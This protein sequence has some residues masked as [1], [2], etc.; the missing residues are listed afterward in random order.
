MEGR[1]FKIRKKPQNWSQHDIMF[2]KANFNFT[3][4]E[5]S[6]GR[7]LLNGTLYHVIPLETYL[8]ILY[9][10]TRSNILKLTDNN[11]VM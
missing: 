9:H 10:S 3:E 8:F 1:P 4:R 11:K 7:A 5:H 6:T 2:E